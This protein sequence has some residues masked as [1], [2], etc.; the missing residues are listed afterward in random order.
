M[1]EVRWVS[2]WEGIS[3]WGGLEAGFQDKVNLPSWFG[4]GIYMHV[5]FGEINGALDLCSL[6][7]TCHTSAKNLQRQLHWDGHISVFVS[8]SNVGQCTRLLRLW[9][10]VFSRHCWRGYYVTTSRSTIWCCYSLSCI[11]SEFICWSP[12]LQYRRTYCFRNG[13]F[14][15]A[16]KLT[17]GH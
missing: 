3:D 5:H 10:K 13:T 11:L 14:K 4:Q 15:W 2:P 6:L 9:R 12:S 7:H 16:I 8:N 1:I 17:C